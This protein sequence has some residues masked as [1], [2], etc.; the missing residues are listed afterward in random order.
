MALR[1][2]A[3][4][5]AGATIYMDITDN[6][7]KVIK[8]MTDLVTFA[9]GRQIIIGGDTNAHSTLWGSP[10]NNNRGDVLEEFLFRHNIAVLNNGSEPTFQ[11]VRAQSIIDVTFSSL[12]LLDVIQDWGVMKEDFLSDHRCVS[13]RLRLAVKNKKVVRM[14]EETPWELFQNEVTIKYGKLPAPVCWTVE[15]VEQETANLYKLIEGAADRWTPSRLVSTSKV[16][17]NNWW[18]E[19]ITKART[20]YK[21]ERLYYLEVGG[22][23]ALDCMTT[24]KRNLKYLIR[25]AKRDSW[26]EFCSEVRDV[27]KMSSLNKMLQRNMN[28][29]VG[30]MNRPT[31]DSAETPEESLD[32]LMQAHFPGC[33]PAGEG[34][35]KHPVG[36]AVCLGMETEFC[37]E[38]KVKFA[39]DKFGGKKAAG[40]D[41]L[42]PFILQKLPECA[43]GRLTLIYRACLTL[44]YVPEAWRRSKVVFLPK[45]GKDDYSQPRSFRPISLTSFFLKG[46]ERVILW[47]LEENVLKKHL[48]HKD[49]HAFRCGR[50]TETALSDVVDVIERQCLRGHFALG[51]FLDIEGAFDNLLPEAVTSE[52]TRR[53]TPPV[54]V[55]WMKYFLNHRLALV[56]YKGV[57]MMKKLVRGTP[58]GGVLSP[59]LWNIC[60]D[61]VLSSMKSTPGLACGFADDLAIIIPGTDP[62][63]L[64]NIGQQAINR[65][66][67]WGTANGLKFSDT[68]TVAV[69]FTRRRKWSTKYVLKI[70]GN[71]IP[72]EK[73]VKYLGVLLDQELTFRPHIVEKTKKAKGLLFKCLQVVGKN[74][75]PSPLIMRWLWTGVVRPMLTYG[76]IVWAQA[77]TKIINE[78]ELKRLNRLAATTWGHFRRSTP[79]AGLEIFGYLPPL[80]LFIR[81]EAT[82]AWLRVK[83]TRGEKWDGVG[84]LKTRK[85][86]RRYLKDNVEKWEGVREISL[87]GLEP[88]LPISKEQRNRDIQEVLDHEWTE[89][90]QSRTDCRQSRMNWP[91]PD[92]EKSLNLLKLQREQVGECIQMLSGHNFLKRHM[93]IAKEVDNPECR[94]CGG[95]NDAE[96]T[97][98]HII[99]ECPAL[100]NE[101][102]RHLGKEVLDQSELGKWCI[103]SL[104][105]FL[106]VARETL[107]N[108]EINVYV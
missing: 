91:K 41:G 103:E 98:D 54:I 52:L 79:T 11:T 76:S 89:R 62:G 26:R 42:K 104:S 85:G 95:E 87:I 61:S 55:K 32:V 24:A 67:A 56:D 82:K 18:N 35:V 29:S 66:L 47:E 12:G 9:K 92:R 108:T 99:R 34:T 93:F 78:S 37:T 83:E 86:H 49:Q 27:D 57:N 45:P 58:Q 50:S 64:I 6:L 22:S 17:K 90:W 36:D 4:H 97:S 33:L 8:H 19:E 51:I 59:L 46:L 68:K 88:D 75:G 81:G 38:T 5:L 25:V 23:S 13:F 74:W 3:Q 2:S 43:L 60:F 53:G 21:R 14:W 72:L 10:S 44:G 7:E 48:L 71:D 105:R 31:G 100:A 94:L 20:A 73:S 70:R 96:E 106:S 77:A 1:G 80:D 28:Q 30:V 84:N 102:C 65:A 107:E 16:K 63:T 15:T 69:M 101:R 39:V 40:P